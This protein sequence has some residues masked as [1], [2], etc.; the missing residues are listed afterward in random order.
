MKLTAMK[1]LALSALF[2]VGVAGA[3]LTALPADQA[4]TG[5]LPNCHPNHY[6][7]N[8]CVPQ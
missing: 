1:R 3:A 6:S 2:V 8:P 7:D 5:R 4:S